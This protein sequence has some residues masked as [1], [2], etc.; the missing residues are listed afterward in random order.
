VPGVALGVRARHDGPVDRSDVEAWVD[1]Y[2][3]A[4]GSND[5][6]EIGALFTE[7]AR[8]Y[9][10]P[11]RPP[12]E[13]RRDIVEG[14]LDR[15]DESGTWSFRYEVLAVCDDLGF[16]RGWT[17]SRDD[18]DYSNLWVIRQEED[19]RCSEFVEWWMELTS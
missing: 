11:H 17:E 4:W 3:Q 15:R 13:G 2:V 12:W 14:W 8:Y 6:A 9:T 16:V 18:H 1:R 19:G 10:A 7:D 5:P